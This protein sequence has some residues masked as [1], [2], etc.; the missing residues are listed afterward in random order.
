MG[1]VYMTLVRD[2][3]HSGIRR[4]SVNIGE[5]PAANVLFNYD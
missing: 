4:C 3:T 5:E 1:K 2:I